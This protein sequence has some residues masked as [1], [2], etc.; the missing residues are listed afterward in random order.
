MVKED[1]SNLNESEPTPQ[2]LWSVFDSYM[3]KA[4]AAMSLDKNDSVSTRNL[5]KAFCF[6]NRHVFD[7]EIK[8]KM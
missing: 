1:W 2:L 8:A 5:M 7:E 6:K 3:L 4:K